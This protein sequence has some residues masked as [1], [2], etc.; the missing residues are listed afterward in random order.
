LSD[1]HDTEWKSRAFC[2]PTTDRSGESGREY[3]G[4]TLVVI[5]LC[6]AM[7]LE[8][9][10]DGCRAV[11]FEEPD[12]GRASP[13]EHIRWR[14][15]RIVGFLLLNSMD[16]IEEDVCPIRRSVELELQS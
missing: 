4:L 10:L 6:P 3:A 2:L 5:G 13:P 12:F 16:R 1:P 7:T 11:A 9:E 14:S 15:H 8:L